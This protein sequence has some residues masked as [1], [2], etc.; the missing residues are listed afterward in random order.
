[1]AADNANGWR[2]PRSCLPS[3]S[4]DGSHLPWQAFRWNVLAP[5]RIRILE[6]P[7]P[8][9]LPEELYNSTK[10][11]SGNVIRYTDQITA[12]RSQAL[13]GRGFGPSP[14]FP[15]NILPTI[16]KYTHLARCMIPQFN[17]EALPERAPNQRGSLYELSIPRSGLGCGFSVEAFDADELDI[18]PSWLVTTGTIVHFKTGYVSP[19]A[20]VYCPFLTFERV[21][22]TDRE[23]L[24]A[25]A[26]Q[27]AIGG[28][29]CVRALHM[30]YNKAYGSKKIPD[31]PISFSC[32]I[33]NDVAILNYHWID[34]GDNYYMAPLCKFDLTNDD[35]FSKFL[36]WIDAIGVW[37]TE[38]LLPKVKA[39]L[40]R[41]RH[42]DTT[43]PATPVQPLS[44][45]LS[46]ETSQE[47]GLIKAL[48]TNFNTI[49][50][51]L[52][53]DDFTP[54]SSSTA[55]W[56]SPI[57]GDVMMSGFE[58]T[59]PAATFRKHGVL[60]IEPSNRALRCSSGKNSTPPPAYAST[61]DLVN[62][63]RLDHAMDEIRD[64]H[65][66]LQYLKNDMSTTTA[67]NAF[68]QNELSAVKR[69]L[70]TVLRK[71]T[72]RSRNRS[73]G[74]EVFQ[75]PQRIPSP[76]SERSP[77][78]AK[79]ATTE[80]ADL[81]NAQCRSSTMETDVR[82]RESK[83]L[84]IKGTMAVISGRLFGS[85]GLETTFQIFVLGCL[86]NLC[87]RA[88][89]SPCAGSSPILDSIWPKT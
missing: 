34:H 23:H 66:Q 9:G 31:L 71:E 86:A 1:M 37:A 29:W 63:K 42:S 84:P 10:A 56:G 64:L 87:M 58:F 24:E 77:S 21:L 5:H 16:D 17:R 79:F 39:A 53:D 83:A 30:L 85:L 13:A 50:W 59:T 8:N 44:L 43:P 62:Q 67:S 38:S 28:S 88:V 19:G 48:K 40:A 35:H 18:L 74:Q 51:Q 22:A 80:A 3:S 46:I 49:P 15:P 72:I 82:V 54:V 20:A 61:P 12:F 36:V 60:D 76:E 75:I 73:L 41:I 7:P 69:T 57:I 11:Q 33:N 89:L 52:E 26:N 68:L 25:A 2:S 4:Y 70:A 65:Q 27:C 47:Q 78:K 6:S 55:S 81:K 32:T 45:S 14:L